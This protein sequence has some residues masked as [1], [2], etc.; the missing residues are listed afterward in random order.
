[1]SRAMKLSLS[2]AVL[3]TALL[4]RGGATVAGQAAGVLFVGMGDSIREGVQSAD[5]SDATQPHTFQNIIAG[6]M[7]ASYPLPLIH[8]TPVGV[9]GGPI[10]GRARIDPTV[11]GLDLAVSGADVHSTLYDRSLATD[12]SQITT[13]TGLVLFPRIGSQIEIA[14]ALRPEYVAC[15]IGN[16]DALDAAISFNHLDASQLTPIPEFTA[17]FT[18]IADRLQALGSKVVFATIPD[19]THIGFLLDQQDLVRF[20]GTDYGFPDG[21]R[22]SVVAMLMVK[23]GLTDASIFSNPDYVLDPA[24]IQ[25]ISD[26]ITALNGVIT[27]VAASHGFAVVDTHAVFDSFAQQSPVLFGV[28]LTPRL[29]GGLF[30]QDGIHPSDTAHALLARYFIDTFNRQYGAAIPQLDWTA[31]RRIVRADPFLDVNNNGRVPGRFGKGLLETLSPFLGFSGDFSDYLTPLGSLTVGSTTAARL[32][33]AGAADPARFFEEYRR[34]TGK[35]LRTMTWE[36]Q[37]KAFDELFDLHR[38][39]ARH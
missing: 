3:A 35:E 2:S 19:V 11:Q 26:H 31:V 16:N 30:S 4:V 10:G 25:T 23:L 1:M 20:L 15:W 14:E 29:L 38:G 12:V 37:V 33:R 22:T 8:T 36:Q 13:E 5:A 27:S 17:D 28:T 34:R 21:S 39:R 32:P 7:A 24:E 18:Q 6:Q 9:V